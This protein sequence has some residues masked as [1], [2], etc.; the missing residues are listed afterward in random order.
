MSLLLRRSAFAI[1]IALLTSPY[2]AAADAVGEPVAAE[3]APQQDGW[4]FTVAP[5]FWAAGLQG[6]VGLFGRQP[7]DIDAD[8]TDI[9][10]NLRFGG[11]VVGEAHNG[12]WGILADLVYVKIE[13]EQTV[14]RTVL[15][16]P[17][18]LAG[19]IQTSS[20]TGT[21]MGEYRVVAEPSATMDIMAGVRI[22][23]VDTDISLAL[24]AGGSPIAGLSGS[25]GDTW[26]DPMVGLRGRIDLNPS[27]YLTGWGM[28]GG[29]DAGSDFGWDILGGLGHQ[30]NDRVSVVG[31]YRALGVDYENDGF[32]FDAVQH[33]PVLGAVFR[34]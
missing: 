17:L 29:F 14:E 11:M 4:V 33:G 15:G 9:F 20:F 23:S 31:G 34:F 32:V 1:A 19:D 27:W 21:I 12:A 30:F 10:D 25:D 3:A 6:D 22:W 8:F 7:V 13:V 5:Y 28:V 2:A 16:V 26:V 24:T 18:A